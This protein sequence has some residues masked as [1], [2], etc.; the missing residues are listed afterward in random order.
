MLH[1]RICDLLGIRHPI[2][3]G[4][5]GT[6]T[7]P[8]LAAA[9][10]NAGGLGIMSVSNLSPDQQ[11]TDVGRLHELTKGPFG[12]N[13]LLFMAQ[14]ERLA[15]TV[16]LRPKVFSTAWPWPDQDLKMYAEMSRQAGALFMHMVSSVPEAVRAAEAGADVIVAQGTEGGGHVG[17]M[18]TLPLVPMVV[19][20]VA[21]TPVLAA[22]GVADGQGLA[23]ALALGADG[24]LL[25]TRFM[26]TP[27]A[28]IPQGYKD[29]IV[30]D[31]GHDTLLTEIPDTAAGRV[32]PGAMLRVARNRFIERWAGREWEVRQRRTEIARGLAQARANN[33]MDEASLMMG[34]TAGLINDIVPAGQLVER[35][36]V[37]AEAILRDRLAAMLA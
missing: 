14:E 8:E 28:P 19:R 30:R 2:V 31:D 34:Q 5:M 12:L 37:E 20:A 13:H 36:A 17:W 1:T 7:N 11:R 18:G 4:G 32:W 23:A 25:G 6:A 16:S 10:T 29:A 33:D 27:E 35:I 15:A 21:P 9:V 22:G 26:A 3:L 24:V